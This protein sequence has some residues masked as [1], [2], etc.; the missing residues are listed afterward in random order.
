MRRAL[1]LSFLALSA[2]VDFDRLAADCVARGDCQSTV[3][4]P[5]LLESSPANQAT[6]VRVDASL[7]L[8]FS[9]AM[10]R[11]SV[12]LTLSPPVALGAG[13]WSDDDTAYSVQPQAPLTPSTSYTVTVAGRSTDGAALASGASFTFTT[14]AA[15]DTVAPTLASTQ[16][17]NGAGSV[18]VSSTVTLVFSEAMSQPSL[19]L[20]SLPAAT[21]GAP[22]WS[23][24]GR[25]AT[26]TPDPLEGETL[27]TLTVTGT[28]LAG[29]ALTGITTLTFTTAAAPPPPDTTPPTV[30]ATTPAEGAT[31]VATSLAPTLFFS[32]PMKRAELLAAITVTPSAGI[33]LTTDDP[34]APT[35]VTLT[36]GAPLPSSTAY[37]VTVGVGAVDLAGNALAAPK[38]LTFT[39]GTTPDTTPPT[40]TSVD[41]VDGGV[42]APLQ[43]TLTLVFSEPMDPAATQAALAVSMP[44]G[45]T[46]TPTW[47]SNNTRLQW[48]LTQALT[49]GQEVRWQLGT[50][51][52]DLSGNALAQTQTFS[53]RVRRR[54]TVV[55]DAADIV[56]DDTAL[57][58][59][60]SGLTSTSSTTFRVGDLGTATSNTSAARALFSM[61]LAD[62]P[63][64][65][66]ELETAKLRLN[67][68]S[69]FGTPFLTGSVL[70]LQVSATSTNTLG[71]DVDVR[72][73]E[74]GACRDGPDVPFFTS[75]SVAAVEKDV[76]GWV[77][78]QVLARHPKLN[79]RVLFYQQRAAPFMGGYV[80]TIGVSGSDYVTLAEASDGA[81]TAPR[82]TL[83]FLAP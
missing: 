51:A 54:Y 6:D 62:V 30:V 31:N 26:F 8:V 75:A 10:S 60:S 21:W 5:Q 61:S 27:Y 38:T 13:T 80:E 72:A 50:G 24:D 65:L 12:T 14:Q 34:M 55:L 32:E 9:K 47:S 42:G 66:L 44:S 68:E 17:V 3:T 67:L 15:P 37:T 57:K 43:P 29:N 58:A 52:R 25:T 39:T 74:C 18:P 79:F 63:S 46:G 73:L 76:T 59:V 56:T 71:F 23:T 70:M 53:F 36:H 28:D 22:A 16:P 82:L 11:E 7:S 19:Q 45:L 40:L 41:P 35:Q 4:A 1:F 48:R 64:T 2:C 77:R 49:P 81:A 20:T 69:S 83:Q 78:A 33:V